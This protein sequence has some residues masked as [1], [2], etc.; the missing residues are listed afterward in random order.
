M[1]KAT[2]DII[3]HHDALVTKWIDSK[4]DE[5]KRNQLLKFMDTPEYAAIPYF[6]KNRRFVTSTKLKAYA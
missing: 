3:E 1:V 5:K 6:Q 4:D 2:P